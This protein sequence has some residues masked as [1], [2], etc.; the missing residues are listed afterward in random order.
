MAASAPSRKIQT[1]DKL[2]KQEDFLVWRDDIFRWNIDRADVEEHIRAMV[3]NQKVWSLIKA[4]GWNPYEGDP[5]KIYD[6]VANATE[7]APQEGDPIETGAVGNVFG[8]EGVYIGSVKPNVGHSEGCSGITSV[9]KAVL[10]LEHRTIPPNIKFQE[11]NPK[12]P[13]AEKKLIVPVKPTAFPKNRAE[14]ISVNSFGIGGSN[15][16]GPALNGVNGITKPHGPQLLLFSANSPASLKLQIDTFSHYTAQHPELDRNVT[17]TL[18]LR[19]EK[20]PHRAFA[21]LQGDEF[22]ETH[23]PAK[24]PASSPSIAMIFSGQGAQW[25]GIGRELILNNSSFRQDIHRMDEILKGLRIPPIWSILG[26]L[27][28][29][30][31]QSQLHR[32]ELAQPL[33]TAL[34]IALVR[35]FKR[36]GVTPTA[37]VGHSSGEITAVY[38]AGYLSL[39]Y[40]I[41]LVYYRSYISTYGLAVQV[42]G[43]I[44]AVGL[45]VAKVSRFLQPGVYVAC[46][47]SPISTT[48]SDDGKAVQN[49][50]ATI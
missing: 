5:K 49:A 8:G 22:L 4:I 26:E 14:R 33:S 6:I 35:Q 25:A 37:I 24:G 43:I 40:A 28:K 27:L 21:I 7:P 39:E 45:G 20:L 13:F 16:N 3:P 18:A 2:T 15:A 10:A 1:I 44:A 9:I 11:P 31:D 50:L 42:G 23:I 41:T 30:E 36:L 34:Q 29:P 38:T 47:N 32:A 12:I 46:E 19:R 48:I 17:Y